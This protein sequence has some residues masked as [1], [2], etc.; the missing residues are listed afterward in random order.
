MNIKP[1]LNNSFSPKILQLAKFHAA[2]M[3]RLRRQLHQYPET[4]MEEFQTQ[5]TMAAMLKKAG[6]QVDTKI[7]K[8]AVV[9]VLNGKH[10]GKTIGIRSDMDALPVTEQTGYTFASKTMGRMHACGHDAHMSI[11]WGAAKIL[12]ELKDELNGSIKFVYQPS[13]EKHPGGAKAVNR[14]WRPE[15]SAG[16]RDAW[17]AC[18]SDCTSRQDR[19]HGWRHDG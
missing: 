3:I 1:N 18:L 2:E 9:G 13:E 7:W 8:T 10:K 17:L 16:I 12:S 4:A 14:P 6:C 5:K 19:Y 11:V 15:K